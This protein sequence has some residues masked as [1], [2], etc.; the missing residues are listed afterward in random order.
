MSHS[1]SSSIDHSIETHKHFLQT[2][3]STSPVWTHTFPPH[4]F[5]SFPSLDTNISN[6]DTETI[7][8]IGAGIAGIQTSYELVTRG[9]TVILLE[10]RHILSGESGRTSG[11]LA[12]AL[13]DGYAN[14]RA[15]HGADKAKVAAESHSWAIQRVEEICQKLGIREKCE[16]RTLNGYKISNIPKGQSGHEEDIKGI[17][18][19]AEAAREAGIDAQFVDGLRIRGWDGSVDQTDGAVFKAQATFH[20][21]RYLASLL[22]WLSQQPGFS[23]YVN[24]RVTGIDEERHGVKVFTDRGYTVTASNVVE[25]TN[26]PLQKLSIVAEMG[27]YRT[28]CIAMRVPKGSV[29]DCLIYDTADPYKYIRLTGCDEAEDY[30]VIG[31]CDHKVGQEDTAGRF[32]ELARWARE[33]FSAAG[34]VDYAWSGQIMEPVDYMAFIGKNQGKNRT[35]VITGDSGNGLTHGVIAGKLVADEIEDRENLWAALYNPRRTHSIRKSITGMF[36]HDLQVN[37]QYKRWVQS[38]VR[39]I[40]DIVPG[41]GGVLHQQGKPVAVYKDQDGNQHKLSAICPH[42]KGV[43][44]WNGTE[45]SWDCP[46]HGS[47]FSAEGLCVQGPAKGGLKVIS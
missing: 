21:T 47:R 11:H 37:A 46:V 39:D 33:R 30:M 28:Y 40:E 45:K 27:Y 44:C 17:K 32:E 12:S 38:D 5:P 23:C 4:D 10:A 29:E 13:D 15:K 41:E 18:E 24:T 25:A 14:I 20:P 31:G 3:G 16:M 7:A 36:K 6:S 19:D 9:H 2:S 34:E 35:Y 1:R 26:I 43:V 8:I 22:D 42:M